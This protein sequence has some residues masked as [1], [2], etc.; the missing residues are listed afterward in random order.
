MPVKDQE[1]YFVI[2]VGII[3]GLLLVSFIVTILFLYQRRQQRQEQEIQHMKD[4]YEKEALRSQLEIQE[5]TM[6]TMAQELHDNIGQML[7][8][9]KL[10]LSVLPIDKEHPAFEQVQNSKEVLNKAIFDLSNLTKSLHTDRIAD[11]GLIESVRY[12]LY[13]IRRAGIIQ[14]QFN[15]EGIEYPFA[16]QKLIF[17]FRI[18]QEVLNNTLKHAKA[19]ELIVNMKFQD[20]IFVMEIKDNGVGFDVEQKK[21]STSSGSGVGLRSLFNRA[22][23]IGADLSITSQPGKGST[24]LIELPILDEE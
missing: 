7:S 8:V 13:A 21:Q 10:S 24:T 1:I 4:M 14:I 15:P 11:I 17:L 3:L 9:T 18:F 22:S 6:K 23:I 5:N 12:E 2:V 20:N 19:T 16:E